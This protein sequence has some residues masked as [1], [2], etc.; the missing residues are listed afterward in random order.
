MYPLIFQ[1]DYVES[2]SR[3]TTFFR[4]IWVI[5]ALI[6]TSLYGLG[7]FVALL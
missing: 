4:G 3:L 7:A 1:A 6:V 5:P 2:H